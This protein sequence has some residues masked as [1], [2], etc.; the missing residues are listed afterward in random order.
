[1]NYEFSHLSGG[2]RYLCKCAVLFQ[3]HCMLI[4]RC[5]LECVGTSPDT[6]PVSGEVPLQLSAAV[7]SR[8][9]DLPVPAAL[10]SLRP[11]LCPLHPSPLLL[12]GLPLPV[13][14]G[15]SLGAVGEPHEVCFPPHRITVFCYMM[16]IGLCVISVFLFWLFKVGE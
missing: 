1:M 14:P 9:S 8:C 10:L 11:H 13:Q 12:P 7:S 16:S 3:P 5:P 4:S 2:S 6:R 15:Q